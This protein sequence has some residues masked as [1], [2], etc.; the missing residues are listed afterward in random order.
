MGTINKNA[1]PDEYKSKLILSN[2]CIQGEED[3]PELE[4]II[5]LKKMFELTKT[6]A[7]PKAHRRP[8]KLE[9]ET[10]KEHASMTPIVK[11]SKEM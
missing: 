10:S 3:P 4:G 6:M 1:I 8:I 9:A 5:F 7:D 2:L 11:G